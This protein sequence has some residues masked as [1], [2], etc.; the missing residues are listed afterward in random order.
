VRPVVWLRIG[1]LISTIALPAS[2][3]INAGV[4]FGGVGRPEAG[5]T[6][7]RAEEPNAKCR[8]RSDNV[9]RS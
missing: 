8:G 2:R 5:F 3:A 6:P 1:Q 9:A 7:G 4:T